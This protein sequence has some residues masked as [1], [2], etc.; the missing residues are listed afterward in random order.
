MKHTREYYESFIGK[1]FKGFKF[2][3]EI[4]NGLSYPSEMN[5]FIGESLKI[6]S[7]GDNCNSFQSNSHDEWH[8]PADLV[9]EQIKLNELKHTCVPQPQ[10]A[11]E[12]ANKISYELDF[13]FIKQMA[14]RMECNK[15]KYEPYNWTKPMDIEQLKQALFRH[16][17]EVMNGDMSDDGRE[18][19]HLEAIACNAMM[20]NYQIKN[21]NK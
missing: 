2:E 15:G 7:F 6:T 5:E 19:G 13:N 11:K 9:I 3:S 18:L 16:V 1:T 20:I 14:E 8:Y 12:S 10:G 17:I 21:N 4:H